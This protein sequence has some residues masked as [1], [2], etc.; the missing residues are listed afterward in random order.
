MAD[1]R[2]RLDPRPTRYFGALAPSR[3]S[4]PLGKNGRMTHLFG[5]GLRIPVPQS[6]EYAVMW[7]YRRVPTLSPKA[8]EKSG[9][10]Q[11]EK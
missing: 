1:R 6:M 11:V 3:T 9:A 4:K 7:E 10:P 5:S 2:L 8:G